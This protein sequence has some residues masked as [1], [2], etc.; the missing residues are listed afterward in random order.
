MAHG[1]GILPS[2]GPPCVV[3][4]SVIVGQETPLHHAGYGHIADGFGP[5]GAV[6]GTACS[7]V[8][9][10]Q[11][12]AQCR[13]SQ[14]GSALGVLGGGLSWR[15]RQRRP[16]VASA[17]RLAGSLG[18]RCSPIPLPCS[19]RRTQSAL[20]RATRTSHLPLGPFI[21]IGTLSAIALE[22]CSCGSEAIPAEPR[23]LNRS[24]L[25]RPVATVGSRAARERVLATPCRRRSHDE[26]G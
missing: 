25:S 4:S 8:L 26:T 24:P 10:A 13:P 19:S 18:G 7:P 22:R 21:I 23:G 9:T 2:R 16:W 11:P 1:R 12:S 17:P 15:A 3:S 6:H 14:P 5:G 20:H